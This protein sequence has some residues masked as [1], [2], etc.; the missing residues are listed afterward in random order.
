MRSLEGS[1]IE[2]HQ[3]NS[4]PY[5]IATVYRPP[6]ATVE[7]FDKIEHLIKLVDNENKELYILGDINCDMFNELSHAT[8][9]L[10]SILELYQLSQVVNKPTC[11]TISTS[12]LLDVCITSNPEKIILSEV[13]STG[14]SDHNL[15]FV[16]R[17]INSVLKSR[18]HKKVSVR[19]YKHF[20]GSRFQED[21]LN[22]NWELLDNELCVNRV[23]TLWKNLFLDVLNKHAPIRTKR[24]RNKPSVPWLTKTIK[25]KI[26]ERNRLKVRATKSNSEH[27]WKTYKISRNAVT[28]ALREAKAIYYR[29]RFESAKREPKQAWKT[30]NQILNRNRQDQI[31]HNI[32]SVNGLITNPTEISECFNN[33][34]ADIGPKISEAIDNGKHKFDDY[35]RKST[36]TFQFR[37]TD[38]SK[39]FNLLLSLCTSKATGIDNIPAKNS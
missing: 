37:L 18:Y 32:E 9:K 8:K 6:N 26:F 10:N 39:V 33:Y 7:I 3:P 12:S 30:V 4:S 16:V 1:C 15:V 28:V 34:F 2:V 36:T 21:L 11:E 25:Q 5:V 35:V 27:D 17:K 19:N 20:N 24:I 38:V 31:I 22:Q 29:N 23:W 14:V 13:I